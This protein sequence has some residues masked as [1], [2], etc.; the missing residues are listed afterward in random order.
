MRWASR[1]AAAWPDSPYYCSRRKSLPN[2]PFA[3]EPY[4]ADLSALIDGELSPPREAEVNDH[5]RTCATCSRNFEA[6]S[7]VDRE[8]AGSAIPEVPAGLRMRLQEQIE[9]LPEREEIVRK[10]AA[11][12]SARRRLIRPAIGAAIAVA[13]SVAVYLTV[14]PGPTFDADSEVPVAIVVEETE[15]AVVDEALSEE[16]AS[17]EPVVVEEPA[18]AVVDET[19]LAVVDEAPREEAASDEPV[20]V[21]EPAVAVVEEAVLAVVDEAPSEEVA[22]D[23]PVAVEESL[24][25][26][27]S[28]SELEAASAEELAVL[29]Q[30]ETIQDLDVISNLEMLERLLAVGEGAG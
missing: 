11:A 18:P 9:S 30:L 14:I 19:V 7:G 8:L 22:S 12:P 5:L 13:A 25:V 6:L 17:D 4:A 23:E 29:L 28:A 27:D 24:A 26:V 3:C 10:R 16:P 20:A 1:A 2:T 15:V 21:E